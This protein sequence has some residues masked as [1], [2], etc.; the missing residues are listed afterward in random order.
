MNAA[1][2]SSKPALKKELALFLVLFLFGILALPGI[3][4]AIG[5]A[6][7][8]AYGGSGFSAFYGAVHADLR[9]GDLAVWFL[10]LSPYLVVQLLRLSVRTFRAL[11]KNQPQI[12]S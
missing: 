9:I 4:Y 3:I 11:G 8:G 1:K 7:F 5:S 10:V 2:Q 12:E 6:M